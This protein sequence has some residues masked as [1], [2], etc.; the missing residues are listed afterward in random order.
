M[1]KVYKI[2]I[3]IILTTLY[4]SAMSQNYCDT[5]QF[6]EA[7]VL[8]KKATATDS[9]KTSKAINYLRKAVKIDTAFCPAYFELG[10]LFHTKAIVSQYDIQEQ[11][12]TNM[13]FRKAFDYFEK[14]AKLCKK[15][16]NYGA[17]YYMGEQF[18]MQREY[19][20]AGHYLEK[21]MNRCDSTCLGYKKANIYYSN[22][23][24]W[25]YW[26]EH[27]FDVTVSQVNNICSSKDELYPFITADGQVFYFSRQYQKHKPNSIYTAL[28]NEFLSSSV[29]GVDSVE[30]FIFAQGKKLDYPFNYE[31]AF[32]QLCVNMQNTEMYLTFYKKIKVKGKYVDAAELYFVAGDDG[33]W[34]E[35]EKMTFKINTANG[36]NGEPSLSRDGNTLYFVSN[37]KGGFGGK[38]IYYCI[39]DSAGSWG[40]PVNLGAIIN[41]I[42][43]E[44]NPFVCYDNKTLYFSSNGHF[45]NGGFDIFVSR[46]NEQ[47]E[48]EMPENFGKPINTPGDETNF[49]TDA[50]GI[51]GYFSTKS[52]HGNGGSD[53]FSVDIPGKF[54]PQE[55]I[56]LG[57]TITDSKNKSVQEYSIKVFN[58]ISNDF[59]EAAENINAGTFAAVI[60]KKDNMFYVTVDAD[61][62]TFGNRL[63][64]GVDSINTFFVDLHIDKLS[65]N[66]SFYLNNIY[67][68][69]NLKLN[70]FSKLILNDFAGYVKDNPKFK[71]NICGVKSSVKD[72]ENKE[73]INK[74]ADVVYRY[75]ISKGV[76]SSQISKGKDIV[77]RQNTNYTKS[78][79][80]IEVN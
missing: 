52:L 66:T 46:L 68:N 16:S 3:T 80:F 60:P 22:Y 18:Y 51:K 73:L 14:S 26:K 56:I 9:V 55:M 35:P 37:R 57:G 34:D 8:Y 1:N 45:G 48:W 2:F 33:Y 71:F 19:S 30:N 75:L 49:I 36:Y 64:D 74:K 5:S 10:R 20:L 27:P 42:N 38:D 29:S 31:T 76:L 61:N 4:F 54:R 70:D 53:I 24:K 79:I 58:I 23:I 62:Y 47:G 41:T 32:R 72:I 7:N 50:R 13:Y 44:Q 15:Y 17:Y 63:I 6:Y 77:L 69:D 78:E 67:F 43:D 59:Y 40:V 21:Y 12:Y 25:K 65:A 39:R 11:V 28:F